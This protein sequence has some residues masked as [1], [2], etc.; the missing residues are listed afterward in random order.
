MKI[1][2]ITETEL[3]MKNTPQY[4]LSKNNNGVLYT[5][6]RFMQCHTQGSVF[7]LNVISFDLTS[8]EKEIML[9]KTSLAIFTYLLGSLDS[10]EFK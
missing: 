3:D 9:V 8:G 6:T 1:E 10:S 2:Y 4:Q 5:E 7:H